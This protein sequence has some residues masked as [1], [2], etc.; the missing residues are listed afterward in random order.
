M[1]LYPAPTTS[2]FLLDRLIELAVI[3]GS[4][5]AAVAAGARV[6]FAVVARFVN[7]G[8]N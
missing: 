4:A 3:E 5:E 6:V 7:L 8:H 1:I 2:N